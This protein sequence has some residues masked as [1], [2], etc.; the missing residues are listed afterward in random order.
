M[1]SF[2]YVPQYDKGE[3]VDEDVDV[4]EDPSGGADEGV[5]ESQGESN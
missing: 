5:N 1:I 2:I 4:G 3:G